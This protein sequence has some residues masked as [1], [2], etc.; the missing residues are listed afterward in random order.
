MQ[1]Q[2]A[3]LHAVR[4]AG[5]LAPMLLVVAARAQLLPEW[6][7][8]VRI[9]HGVNAIGIDVTPD[10]D[11]VL[12]GAEW[13]RPRGSECPTCPPGQYNP[14]DGPPPPERPPP[15]RDRAMK[16]GRVLG[17]TE[18]T[19]TRK[20]GVAGWDDEAT[21][22]EVMRKTPGAL[23]GPHPRPFRVRGKFI[24]DPLYA[25]RRKLDQLERGGAS[26]A[27]LADATDDVDIE[28]LHLEFKRLREH[29]ELPG[30]RTYVFPNGERV[31]D[32]ESMPP[33]KV[34][35]YAPIESA[36]CPNHRG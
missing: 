32:P 34:V 2:R 17:V 19:V 14:Y 28:L 23:A 31:V 8:D 25:F 6:P 24:T 12:K 13:D 5:A 10:G 21:L 18:E 3:S 20:Y 22:R 9:E 35:G 26:E 16:W 15:Y 29:G 11:V 30:M 7:G 27:D 33:G 36:P 1:S 4:R